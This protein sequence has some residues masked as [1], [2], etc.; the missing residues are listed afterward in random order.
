MLDAQL[1]LIFKLADTTERPWLS[2][3]ILESW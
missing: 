2:W 1:K 3:K